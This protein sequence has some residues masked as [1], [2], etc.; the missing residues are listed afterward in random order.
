MAVVCA[1]VCVCVKIIDMSY[2]AKNRYFHHIL[3]PRLLWAVYC[4]VFRQYAV[5]SS[6]LVCLSPVCSLPVLC[7]FTHFSLIW[8]TNLNG[9]HVIHAIIA[10][11]IVFVCLKS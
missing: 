2:L 3:L 8:R 10:S 4:G 1:C 7:Y 11:N 6:T 5:F 9:L